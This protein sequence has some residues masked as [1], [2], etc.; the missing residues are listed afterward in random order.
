MKVQNGDRLP[1]IRVRAAGG[2]QVRLPDHLSGSWSV[3][4]FYRG[5]W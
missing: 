5:H 3:V 4:L 2:A 1:E